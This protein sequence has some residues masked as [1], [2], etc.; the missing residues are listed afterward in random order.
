MSLPPRRA[1]RLRAA[2][3]VKIGRMS[4]PRLA[5]ALA[6]AC[7]CAPAGGP[8][9]RTLH[10]VDTKLVSS[11]PVDAR[12][13]GAYLQSRLALE[14]DPPDLAHALQ[15]I[16][17]ALRHDRDDPHL[18]TTRGQIELRLGD[19]D[20]AR[21]SSARALSFG[22]DYPPALDLAAQLQLPGTPQVAGTRR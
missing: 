16:D 10:Y 13:Y 17:L 3:C 15:Q 11:P 2:K 9:A 7:A 19:R 4:P 21:R 22:P 18:W 14:A 5:L 12:A 8:S 1:G 6:L 20:A